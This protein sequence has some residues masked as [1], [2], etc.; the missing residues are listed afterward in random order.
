MLLLLWLA[1]DWFSSNAAHPKLCLSNSATVVVVFIGLME[2]PKPFARMIDLQTRADRAW[3]EEI[4]LVLLSSLAFALSLA[5]DSTEKWKILSRRGG[6]SYLLINSSA[7]VK[8]RRRGGPCLS[9]IQRL[10]IGGFEIEICFPSVVLLCISDHVFQKCQYEVPSTT[11][12][13]METPMKI[14]SSSSVTCTV[15]KGLVWP[16]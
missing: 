13:L 5:I 12:W 10:W 14:P 2:L 15:N 1:T 7:W 16:S 8:G 6:A 11:T 3:N 4:L 9:G